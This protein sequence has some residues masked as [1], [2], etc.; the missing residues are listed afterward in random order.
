MEMEQWVFDF[1][2]GFGMQTKQGMIRTRGLNE[3]RLSGDIL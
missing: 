3:T 1:G 2:Q